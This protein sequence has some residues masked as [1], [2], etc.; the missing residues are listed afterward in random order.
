MTLFHDDDPRRRARTTDPE[1]SHEA[2]V[3]IGDD[4]N[5]L[6]KLVFGL[7]RRH[8]GKT[9]SE[10]AVLACINDPRVINRRTTELADKKRIVRG[11]ARRCT[12]TG[13]RAATWNL[14]KAQR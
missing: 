11:D 8:P 5:R 9:S 4:L 14:A 2:A 6:H 7:V 10:L 13:R 3:S 1:T 12:V